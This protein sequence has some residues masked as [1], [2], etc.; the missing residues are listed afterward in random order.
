MKQKNI[1]IS[2]VVFIVFILLFMFVIKYSGLFAITHTYQDSV[3]T[4]AGLSWNIKSGDDMPQMTGAQNIA[5][6]YNNP[7]KVEVICNWQD[8]SAY[9]TATSEE[10]LKGKSGNV[11]FTVSGISTASQGQSASCRSSAGVNVGGNVYNVAATSG[12]QSNNNL[13]YKVE[14]DRDNKKINVYLNNRL[15]NTYDLVDDVIKISVNSNCRFTNIHTAPCDASLIINNIKIEGKKILECEEDVD[16]EDDDKC[17][18]D[19]CNNNK[20]EYP[21]IPNCDNG[22]SKDNLIYYILG[23]LLALG[24]GVVGYF[25]WLR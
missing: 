18:L 4:F 10:I 14:I 17:T 16:C 11:E 22:G 13:P 24:G 3:I 2:V 21:K 5:F 12:T 9:T 7:I 15:E 19:F 23:G 20:C 8:S 1:I 6:V 25:K